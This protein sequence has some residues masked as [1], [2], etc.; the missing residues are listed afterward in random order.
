MSVLLDRLRARIDSIYR[1]VIKFG[2]IGL[3]A[4]IIDLGGAN[5]LWST[6]LESRVTTA[7]LISGA[8]ATLFAWAG[9]RLWTF[10][11]HHRRAALPEVLL[12]FGVNGVVLAISAAVLAISHYALGFQ[13]LLAD[14]IATILGIGIGTVFRFVAYRQFV[15]AGVVPPEDAAAGIVAKSLGEPRR[16]QTPPPE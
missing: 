13:S 4:F 8:V 1:E 2:V 3:I 5:L 7:R 14:N 12:F 6:V 9:N 16:T 11:R 10:R 15:F